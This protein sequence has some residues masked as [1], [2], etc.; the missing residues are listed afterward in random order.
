[1]ESANQ[2]A[3]AKNLSRNFDI[4]ADHFVPRMHATSKVRWS[5]LK[6]LYVLEIWFRL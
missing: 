6:R 4:Q 3:S 5:V 2:T 1:M